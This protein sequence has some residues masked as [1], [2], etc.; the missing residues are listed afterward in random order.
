MVYKNVDLSNS[1]DDPDVGEEREKVDRERGGEGGREGEKGW[2]EGTY[3]RGRVH[4]NEVVLLDPF[5]KPNEI[6]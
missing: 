4:R 2:M 3:A 1:F 5:E 6:G